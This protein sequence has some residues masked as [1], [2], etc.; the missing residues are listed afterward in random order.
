MNCSDTDPLW[1]DWLYGE[2]PAEER[3]ALE[4]HRAECSRC[5]A[6]GRRLL[7]TRGALDELA[8]STPRSLVRPGPTRVRPRRRTA[9]GIAAVLLALGGWSLAAWLWQRPD[10]A[11]RKVA[12]PQATAPREPSAA[13]LADLTERL[14]SLE[15]MN[16]LLAGEIERLDESQ[17]R[18]DTDWHRALA[19]QSSDLSKRLD[20][21]DRNLQ[22]LFQA[23]LETTQ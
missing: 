2:L 22:A 8:A 17:A 10:D 16:Q 1:I 13:A 7:A 11:L 9:A 14:Q 3:A 15:E 20:R 23:E 21:I 19:G 12:R 4:A 5:R 18:R 6:A